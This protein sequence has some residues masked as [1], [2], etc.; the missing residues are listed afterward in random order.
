MWW[1]HILIRAISFPIIAALVYLLLNSME[2]IKAGSWGNSFFAAA[3]ILSLVLMAEIILFFTKKQM[4]KIYFN[5]G[6]ILVIFLF[7]VIV[8]PMIG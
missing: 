8:V 4:N 7:V 5:M 3:S 2:G 1:R 6:L